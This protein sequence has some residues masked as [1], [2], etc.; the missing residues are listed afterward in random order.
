[1][2]VYRLLVMLFVVATTAISE[3]APNL[4]A[5]AVLAGTVAGMAS[6]C[7]FDPKPVLYEF[8]ILM[9]RVG[10]TDGERKELNEIATA[11]AGTGLQ[12]QTEPGAMPCTEVKVRM[13]SAIDTFRS[14]K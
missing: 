12:W 13:R 14:A 1:M 10:V 5:A 9:E 4:R 2:T 3:A 6:V 8:R 11:S 7:K